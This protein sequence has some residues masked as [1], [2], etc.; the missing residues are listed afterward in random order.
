MRMFRPLVSAVVASVLVLGVGCAV[1][2][3]AGPSNNEAPAAQPVMQPAILLGPTL[4]GTLDLIGGTVGTV[5]NATGG[6]V[7]LLTCSPQQYAK[8]TKTIGSA[9]GTITVGAH[10]LVIPRG[11]LSRNVTITAEQVRGS[12][13]TV[14]FSPE[15]LRFSKQAQ[16]RLS[17]A[18]CLNL[19]LLRKKVVY[20]DE[21]LN[22]LE[23]LRSSDA[24]Q[25][26]TVTGAI[27]HFSRYAVAY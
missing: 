17:Y 27:D 5:A 9:G 23:L 2:G 26:K 4:E 11:A 18:N 16:V 10:Q 14:R 19:P 21:R 22:I 20:T 15:G 1:D 8:S 12:A 7:Q 24:T 13:N 6:L 25:S 3:P